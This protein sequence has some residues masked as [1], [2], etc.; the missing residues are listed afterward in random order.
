MR[1][2]LSQKLSIIFAALFAVV[3]ALSAVLVFHTVRGELLRTLRGNLLTSSDLIRRLVEIRVDERWGTLIGAVQMSELVTG[4][5][6]ELDTSHEHRFRVFNEYTGGEAEVVLPRMRVQGRV[7]SGQPDVAEE[8]SA[9]FGGIV[10]FYQLSDEGF[11]LVSHSGESWTAGRDISSLVPNGSPVYDLLKRDG[12][13]IG[14]DHIRNAW[15]LTAWRVLRRDGENVG[16]I[17]LALRQVEMERLRQDVLSI[18]IA[19]AAFPYVIDT[20][21][22]VVIHPTLEGESL[23]QYPHIREIQFNRDGL[24]E[25]VRHEIHSGQ[26]TEHVLSH[27]FIPSMN[28]IVIAEASAEQYFGPL[29]VLQSIFI[30]IFGAAV[31][32][33]AVLSFLVGSRITRPIVGIT[34]KIKEIS[35]G[36]A[37]LSKHLNVPSNDEVGQL[38]DYFNTFMA[39]LRRL[40][41]VEQREIDMQLRDAQMNALQA[42]INPHFLYNTLETIR[43]MIGSAADPAVEVVQNLADL[44]RVSIGHGERYVPFRREL[45]HAGLYLA[46]QRVRYEGRFAVDMD[47]DPRI[48]DL[49]TAK[50]ILQPLVENSLLHGFQSLD[51]G[52]VITVRCALQEGGV[53]VTVA[54]NGGG[55]NRSALQTLRTRLKRRDGSGSIG[56]VNVSERIRL[57]FGDAYGIRIDSHVDRGTTV[58]LKLPLLPVE[59]DHA[60]AIAEHRRTTVPTLD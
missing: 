2:R 60:A 28:W 36:E 35:E 58:T 43:F 45:E 4:H 26:P 16:A 13:Y 53:V 40:K 47:V 10:A 41:E 22:R 39:K 29:R 56:L 25:G 42:Q 48:L 32:A 57:Y 34:Q 19:D 17:L 5:Q 31:I 37:D 1:H 33:A 18:R 54:D 55:M 27:A 23:W 50:F 7:V 51:H 21:S 30:T 14:R 8:I 9:R 6:A 15:Y 12:Y 24:L 3:L 52:G 20:S 46:I 59:P 49:Y 11:V 38:C 44:L